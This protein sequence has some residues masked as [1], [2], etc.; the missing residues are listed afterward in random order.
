MQNQSDIV[1][2][3]GLSE[4]SEEDETV[5]DPVSSKNIS[6][7]SATHEEKSLR[8]HHEKSPSPNRR[9]YSPPPHRHRRRS[10]S[11]DRHERQR[12]ER[13]KSP[14]E[15]IH[16]R[17][18]SEISSS[19]RRS[20]HSPRKEDDEEKL[21]QA[22]R[23]DQR[24]VQFDWKTTTITTKDTPFKENRS[25]VILTVNSNDERNWKPIFHRHRYQIFDF[26]YPFRIATKTILR[27][28][29][30][31]RQASIFSELDTEKLSVFLAQQTADYMMGNFKSNFVFD[32]FDDWFQKIPRHQQNRVVICGLGQDYV[33]K[34]AIQKLR[35]M[36]AVQV[37]S[38]DMSSGDVNISSTEEL[39][40]FLHS[41]SRKISRD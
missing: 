1:T 7:S 19:L 13:S 14:Q 17:R 34:M 16:R 21:R 20:R 28:N 38:V 8:K 26:N 29:P 5:H 35:S 11:P 3:D 39:E 22:L 2:D 27:Q 37:S 18:V 25:V 4:L 24:K 15:S 41:E 31:Y 30:G 36:G 12:R 9:T 10:P 23:R 6:K 32:Y 40:K 33:F